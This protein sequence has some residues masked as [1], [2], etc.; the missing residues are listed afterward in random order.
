MENWGKGRWFL[1]GAG[2]KPGGMVADRRCE[3]GDPSRRFERPRESPGQ[4]LVIGLA[5]Q[6]GECGWLGSDDAVVDRQFYE[7]KATA[8]AIK[9]S[10][11]ETTHR[12]ECR[13]VDLADVLQSGN[14]IPENGQWAFPDERSSASAHQSASRSNSSTFDASLPWSRSG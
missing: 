3:Y 7:D 13:V 11:P 5:F 2:G 1:L 4:Q 14:R 10:P 6:I 12:F 8:D 9:R